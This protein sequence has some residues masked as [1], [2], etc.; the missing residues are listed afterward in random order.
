MVRAGTVCGVRGHSM[1]RRPRPQEICVA[2]LLAV[3]VAGTKSAI[4]AAAEG[5]AEGETRGGPGAGGA[6]PWVGARGDAFPGPPAG[7]PPGMFPGGPPAA[8]ETTVPRRSAPLMAAP[9]LPPHPLQ[10]QHPDHDVI[11]CMAGCGGRGPSIA[12]IAPRSTSAS[13]SGQRIAREKL[14]PVLPPAQPSVVSGSSITT[15]AVTSTRHGQTASVECFAGCGAS[16]GAKR[17][18]G[19]GDHR[20]S[21]Q[22]PASRTVVVGSV[23]RRASRGVARLTTVR[24]RG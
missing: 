21:A 4:P 24:W 20:K 12:Y 3:A 2:L 8:F 5:Y 11:V 15:A 14:A 23:S 18:Q 1:R 9:P 7:A 16:P 19:L 10:L 17:S 13:A 6:P 22:Q